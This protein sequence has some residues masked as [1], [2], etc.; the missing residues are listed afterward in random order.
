MQKTPSNS[1][2][3]AALGGCGWWCQCL[4][5]PNTYLLLSSSSSEND[6][7]KLPPCES[8][9][10]FTRVSTRAQGARHA[11][12]PGTRTAQRLFPRVAL[13]GALTLSFLCEYVTS[14]ASRRRPNKTPAPSLAAARETGR[15]RR[16]HR[17]LRLHF[18]HATMRLLAKAGSAALRGKI[19]VFA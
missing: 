15:S 5:P 19:S 1:N 13:C 17:H 16:R 4:H 8:S 10:A 11:R 14:C 3:V 18:H 6:G 12:L 7:E 9:A 2:Q